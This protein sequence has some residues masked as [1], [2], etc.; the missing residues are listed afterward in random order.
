MTQP[1][2][3]IA[4]A[5]P[6]I[7]RSVAKALAAEGYAVALLARRREALEALASELPAASVWPVD[8][9]DPGA[10]RSVIETVI[11][12]NGTP[13]VLHYNAAGWHEA[14]PLT[15]DPATFQ[16][17]LSLCATGALA[18]LQ[19]VVPHMQAAGGGSLLFTGGGLALY[20]EYGANVVSL[21]A[22]KAAMRALVLALAPGLAEHGIHA[23]TVTVTGTV[24]PGTPFDPDAIAATFMRLHKQPR[25]E[26]QTEIVFDGKSQH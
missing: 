4:G 6:G 9:G 22:G 5:G 25:S 13:A 2:A 15:L 14:D 3:I 8:L 17:D 10:V 7:G 20:P 16:A 1:L 23:A 26:W 18:A 12:A 11:A 21:T 24:A 19:A